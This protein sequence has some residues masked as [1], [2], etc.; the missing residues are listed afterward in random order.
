VIALVILLSA[1]VIADVVGL[2]ALV[3]R[4]YG[5]IT[6]GFLLVFVLPVLTVGVWKL[7]K[8]ENGN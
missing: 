1:I 7:R 2:T 8:L 6:Y 4:G 3:A 5:V